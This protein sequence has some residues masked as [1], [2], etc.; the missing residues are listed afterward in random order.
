[1]KL[2]V[3]VRIG[4][5]GWKFIIRVMELYVDKYYTI[6]LRSTVNLHGIFILKSKAEQNVY[7]RTSRDC[8]RF[9]LLLK[10]HSV[11]PQC[12]TTRLNPL[13]STNDEF[14][15]LTITFVNKPEVGQT[16]QSS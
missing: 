4:E 8:D 13:C 7:F 11:V 9:K 6:I 2:K 3:T 12:R 14:I 16:L 15:C 1:M 10:Y 5:G